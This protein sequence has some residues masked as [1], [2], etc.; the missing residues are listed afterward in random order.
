VAP[1]W[2]RWLEDFGV[3]SAMQPASQ[4]DSL[5]LPP[6]LEVQLS[7]LA[8]DFED[9]LECEACV[10]VYL[11]IAPRGVYTP[12]HMS[13]I[14]QCAFVDSSR[15]GILDLLLFPLRSSSSG[16]LRLRGMY[17]DCRH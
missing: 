11:L 4:D 13:R 15:A 12:V 17:F 7:E 14:G 5:L 10:D 16:S 3:S 1:G 6:F 8:E 2:I 9:W